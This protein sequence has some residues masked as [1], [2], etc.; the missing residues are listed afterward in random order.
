ML[1]WLKLIDFKG[2]Q[3]F[4]PGFKIWQSLFVGG[5]LFLLLW[6]G[7]TLSVNAQSIEDLRQQQQRLERSR[8]HMQ[9]QRDRLQ[10]QESTAQKQLQG[11][12]KN[13]KVT[14]GQIKTSEAQLKQANTQ[15]QALEK[16]L[17]RAEKGFRQKQNATVARLRFL[18]RQQVDRGWAVL[19]QSENISGFLARRYHL[20]QVYGSDRRMLASLRKQADQIDQQRNQIEQKKNEI[21]LLTQQ[22]YAQKADYQNQAGSQQSLIVRLQG[23]R[24]ALE[25]AETQLEKDSQNITVLIQQKL[26]A[27]RGVGRG[28]GRM[29]FPC[30]AVVTSGFGWRIHPILGY[31]RF[32]TGIDFGADYG[33]PINAADSGSVIFAGWYGGY[34]NAVVIDH[35]GSITTLYGHASQLYVSEGQTVKRGQA[36]AAVGSTGLST[37]PHL[38]F[39][40]RQNGEPT[41]PAPYL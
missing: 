32:H 30:N 33:T 35:G 20:K 34:G 41:D 24:R 40:V 26:M 14:D 22:L 36:I 4:F 18:Q 19:L 1:G 9:Q 7:N 38:H 12:Q 5:C 27:G 23:D 16:T 2:M 8:S 13:I 10:K 37:G 15:L 39:E 28:S 21:A 3:R 17:T 11:I 6:S 29:I 31:K 25:V